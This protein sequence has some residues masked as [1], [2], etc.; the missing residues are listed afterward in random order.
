VKQKLITMNLQNKAVTLLAAILFLILG[1]NT[2]VLT[3]VASRKYKQAMLAKSSLIGEV[4]Q[5]ELGKAVNL[6]IPVESLE[7]VNEKLAELVSGDKGIG[8]A[9]VMD[10]KGKILFHDKRDPVGKELNDDITKKVLV[11][12]AHL[13]QDADD[14]F[15]LSFPLM[16]A[17]NKAAGF[18]RMGVQTREIR[19]QLYELLVWALGIS[20]FCFLT[21]LIL[22]YVAI[23]KFITKPIVE[24]E[25]TADAIAGG[26]LTAELSVSGEDEV[27]SLQKAINR[28][29]FNLKDML[30][31]VL[32]ITNG[33]TTVTSNIALSSQGVL[34]I[35]DVQKKA[36][37]ETAAT[38]GQT[39]SSIAQVAL[40]AE[41]LS[42]SATIASSSVHEL[43]ASIEKVAEHTNVF[44]ETA[45]ETAS[46][47]EEMVSTIKSIAESLDT[48]SRSS[49]AI[50]SS[51][52]EVNATTRNIDER[53][54][55]SVNLAE[56]VMD[57]A[58]QKGMQSAQ[59][60]MQ[61]MEE[62]RKGVAE[63]SDIINNLGKRTEDIGKILNVIDDVADQTNLLAINAAILASKAGEH[64]KGFA[65]VADEIKSLAE[66]TSFSTSEIAELIRSVQDATR[67]SIQM[68][69]EGVNTVDKGLVLVTDVNG[70]LSDIV[71]SSRASTEMAR[72]I[73]RATEEEALAIKQITD[74]VEKM[75]EQTENISR[76]IQEQSKGSRF[77]IE[78]TDRVKEMSQQV[79]NATS[80]QKDRSREIAGVIE[81]MTTQAYHIAEA[82]SKH[83]NNSAE[84]VSSMEKIRN[85]T[86][87]LINSSN[88]MNE[89][90][91][92]LKED[93]FNLLVELKKFKV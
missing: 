31:K 47:I 84:M 78:A 80:E 73:Q 60:A 68:A 27:A 91:G 11:S 43:S 13:V 15:D 22:F 79:K 16:T 48:L 75:S 7:G 38:I 10:I 6:G 51:I 24:M 17:D 35:S 59:A 23:A 64:G 20:S 12:K 52:D 74:S 18:L 87:R 50:A 65:V 93:A 26:D 61:G 41:S 82:I 90:V 30:S 62:I 57:K 72:A 76:A 2:A 67:T 21:S 28:M 36:I 58:S 4:M 29:T 70:A 69:S 55:E 85:T 33:V 53:A 71:E 83:K 19:S 63:L 54:H 89:V 5:K 3:G 1:L 92:S 25:K 39:D 45:H 56:T 77:I 81:N 14:Y 9:M 86:G 88:D 32:N 37:E 66:R 8:Y 34:T 40:S 49:E 42:G 46:S 44:S